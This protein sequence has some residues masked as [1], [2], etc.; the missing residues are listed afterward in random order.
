MN[1]SIDF[2][3]FW[4]ALSG[5]G[6]IAAVLFSLWLVRQDNKSKIKFEVSGIKETNMIISAN[7]YGD[8]TPIIGFSCNNYSKFPVDITSVGLKIY[9]KSVKRWT[10]TILKNKYVQSIILI[11]PDESLRQYSALPMKIDSFSSD[12]FLISLTFFEEGVK[13]LLPDLAE[14]EMLYVDFYCKDSFGNYFYDYSEFNFERIRGFY[15]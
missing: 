9:K 7:G 2:G 10:F 5:I 8:A 3:N 11:K 4:D 12:K 6:T 15:E 1:I 13:E 14:S